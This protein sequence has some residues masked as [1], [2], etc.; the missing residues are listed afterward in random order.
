LVLF[1]SLFYLSFF[2]SFQKEDELDLSEEEDFEGEGEDLDGE[3][4]EDV[5]CLSI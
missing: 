5:P 4:D 1:F 2:S 3:E